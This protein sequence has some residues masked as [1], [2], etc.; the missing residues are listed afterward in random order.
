MSKPINPLDVLKILQ[1]VRL[2]SSPDKRVIKKHIAHYLGIPYTTTTDRQI[3][4][5]VTQLR[6]DGHPICSTS[7]KSGY[8]YDPASVPIVIAD[9]R[10]RIVDM[11]ETIR[12]LE[13]GFIPD[14]PTQMMLGM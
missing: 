12:A 9:M 4:D 10:S 2:Y 6:K 7:G 3:R 5:A 11:S 8:W 13:K 14:Q 1:C